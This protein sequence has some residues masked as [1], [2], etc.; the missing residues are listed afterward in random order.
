M[1]TKLDDSQEPLYQALLQSEARYRELVEYSNVIILRW[2]QYGVI[3][4][5]NEY[6]QKFFG[7]S[8]E[9]II[10]KHVV[11][12]IVPESESSGRDLR[13]LMDDICN[14]P[15][16]YE[17]NINENITRSGKR[18]WVAW[19][20]K[21][22]LDDAGKPIG[23]MSVGSDITRQRLLEE[24]LKQA[25]KMQAVGQLAGGIAHDFNNLLQGIMGYAEIIN[26]DNKGNCT[27]ENAIKILD[28]A[29]HAADLT[30]QLLTFARKGKYQL[31]DCNLHNLIVDVIIILDRTIDKRI[32]IE[33]QFHAREFHVLG[34]AS[35]LRSS[36][37][38]LALNA[39]DAM[40]DGGTLLFSTSNIVLQKEDINSD[41][42]D[43]DPGEF[44]SLH[45]IDTGSGMDKKTL[46]R[47]FEP[48]FTTKEIG[49]GTGLG[50]AAVYGAV[51]LHNGII[52]CKSVLGGGSDMKIC[53]PMIKHNRSVNNVEIVEK[54]SNKKISLM[55]V[56]DELI[57]RTYTKILFEKNG[58]KVTGFE[59]GCEALNY[60]K[61]NW[62][63]I[64]LVLLDMI[65][66]NMN[67][68]ELFVELKKINPNIKAILS[69]GYSIDS[70][71][72]ELLDQGILDY[73]EKPFTVDVFEK[74]IASIFISN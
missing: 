46:Q 58:H 63:I 2:D 26:A 9:E 40:P 65:M 3:T 28:T 56:D 67:G 20:N 38:N 48:F 70:E 5:F 7:Y 6:A 12:T 57:V 68:H 39:K 66:P 55:L 36:I 22:L 25:Q 37:L 29:Q 51:H 21:V 60:Y 43:A 47:M 61:K 13:P 59:G 32:K 23:A 45:I 42:F 71:A 11:G 18:V 17:Y 62:K 49:K 15:E 30:K 24:E 8:E 16:Q 64:D 1:T 44:L 52:N 34:D 72:Q 73:I 54:R 35:Q 69:T 4:F 19:T 74:K 10:G 50:L 53:L 14:N 33:K 27:A 31:A 41:E